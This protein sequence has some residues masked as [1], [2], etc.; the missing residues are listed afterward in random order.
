MAFM[1]DG[2]SHHQLQIRDQKASGFGW[3][4]FGWASG[5]IVT[6][7]WHWIPWSSLSCNQASVPGLALIESMSSL[8]HQVHIALSEPV[9]SID[10]EG[11]SVNSCP[12]SPSLN[13]S[14]IRPYLCQVLSAE[15]QRQIKIRPLVKSLLADINKRLC[16]PHWK[17]TWFH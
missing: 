9:T 13:P 4:T 5:I 14:I 15:R 8:T 2:V 16:I 10:Q 7:V 12:I 11:S 6:F 1:L 3:A 17:R